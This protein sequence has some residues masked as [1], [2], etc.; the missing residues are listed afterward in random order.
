MATGAGCPDVQGGAIYDLA[1]PGSGNLANKP[2][3]IP[4]TPARHWR[5]R[6]S[7][8]GGGLGQGVPRL[9]VA[10]IPS[11]V[12]FLAGGMGPFK[13]LYGNADAQS[14]A[15]APGAILNPMGSED[16]SHPSLQPGRATLE[17]ARL[18]GGATRLRPA[19]PGPDWKR[20]ILW[21]IL[22]LG[23]GVL[24]YMAWRLLKALG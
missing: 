6:I 15:L 9:E 23:V 3:V 10:W 13:L 5:V 2:I 14:L 1:L 7:E 12:V 16:V 18:L 22:L 21:S 24:A 19:A 8:A 17:A 4:P 11:E 20:W